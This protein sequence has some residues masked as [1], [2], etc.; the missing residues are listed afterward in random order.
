[1]AP[2]NGKLCDHLKINTMCLKIVA[3]FFSFVYLSKQISL[4]KSIDEPVLFLKFLQ[5]FH[6]VD[7]AKHPKNDAVDDEAHEIDSK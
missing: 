1:M 6:H 2:S 4:S 3:R 5:Y 7:F